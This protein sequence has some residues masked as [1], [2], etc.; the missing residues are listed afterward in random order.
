[1]RPAVGTGSRPELPSRKRRSGEP[2]TR[3]YSPGGGRHRHVIHARLVF[4][5]SRPWFRRCVTWRRS[6][7]PVQ[8]SRSSLPSLCIVSICHPLILESWIHRLPTSA[9][10][11]LHIIAY[12]GPGP[13]RNHAVDSGP[14]S[15][16]R[17]LSS[18]LF[19]PLTLSQPF[20]KAYPSLPAYF[21]W[22]T[23]LVLLSA[24]FSRSCAFTPFSPLQPLINSSSKSFNC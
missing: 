22:S 1:M 13:R 14:L 11:F 7:C 8:R 10:R 23:L 18:L 21:I 2:A 19:P 15:V 24:L 6:I 3:R 17:R 9:L 16:Q 5:R 12:S 20:V 4:S